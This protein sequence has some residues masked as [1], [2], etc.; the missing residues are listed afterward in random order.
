[1]PRESSEALSWKESLKL[2]TFQKLG[3]VFSSLYRMI[4]TWNRQK[5][6]SPVIWYWS[7][8]H[9]I[10]SHPKENANI[11]MFMSIAV[12]LIYLLLLLLLTYFIMG[13]KIHVQ[14]HKDTFI[15]ILHSTWNL[16]DLRNISIKYPDFVF[17]LEYEF[18]T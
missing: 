12:S 1:M 18:K 16:L 6:R 17:M 2:H 13:R 3:Y 15:L 8:Q 10:D 9:Q 7:F 14:I 4:L 11:L 5:L